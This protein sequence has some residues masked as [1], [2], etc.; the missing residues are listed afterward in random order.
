[1]RAERNL[2][3]KQAGEARAENGWDQRDHYREM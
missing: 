2:Y 3:E 1:M